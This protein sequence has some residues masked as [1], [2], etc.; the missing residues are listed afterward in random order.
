MGAPH[1]GRRV[2]T[3]PVGHAAAGHSR[4][5]AVDSLEIGPVDA[6]IVEAGSAERSEDPADRVVGGIVRIVPLESAAPFD[7]GADGK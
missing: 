3:D 5:L 4:N 1:G 7:D 2:V 6:Q